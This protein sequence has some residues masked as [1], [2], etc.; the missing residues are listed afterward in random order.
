MLRHGYRLRPADQ[1]SV[2]SVRHGASKSQ[3]HT[4]FLAGVVGCGLWAV[5]V[6]ERHGRC[7]WRPG[8]A[9]SWGVCKFGR[10]CSFQLS[11]FKI[12]SSPL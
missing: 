1:T 7:E 9:W 11:R 8:Y 4:P 6:W 3:V 2:R 10:S 12:G 5:W